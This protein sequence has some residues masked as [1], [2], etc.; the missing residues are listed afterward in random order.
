MSKE[1]TGIQGAVCCQLKVIKQSSVCTM[2]HI[3]EYTKHRYVYHV[4]YKKLT[5]GSLKVMHK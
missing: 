2:V 3:T 4:E 1:T 5:I